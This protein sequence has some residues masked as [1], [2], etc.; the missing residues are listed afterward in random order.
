MET[1]D[2][3]VVHVRQFLNSARKQE[4]AELAPDVLAHEDAELRRCLAWAL[5]VIDDF[6]DTEMDE[7]IT[8]VTLAG[9]LYIAPKDYRRLSGP[10]QTALLELVD[11]ATR[12]PE[13][14]LSDGLD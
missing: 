11:M 2:R 6:A 4:P 5:D 10:C 9:G 3:R 1:H 13:Y 12:H 7:D 8:Q 14:G